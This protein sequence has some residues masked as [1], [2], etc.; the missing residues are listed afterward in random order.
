MATDGDREVPQDRGYTSRD[1]QTQATSDQPLATVYRE[2]YIDTDPDTLGYT[3]TPS[4]GG[5]IV[6]DDRGERQGYVRKPR[7]PPKDGGWGWMVV[8]GK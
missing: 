8:V 5:V 6:I 2:L 4:G 1:I 7:L 3:D